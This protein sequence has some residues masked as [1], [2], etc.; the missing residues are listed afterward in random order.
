MKLISFGL[1]T[2]IALTLFTAFG[3]VGLTTRTAV[4]DRVVSVTAHIVSMH[5]VLPD[6][7][8]MDLRTNLISAARFDNR[9]TL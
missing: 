6:G 7:A 5:A 1:A 4:P 8:L 3:S 2:A 9:S